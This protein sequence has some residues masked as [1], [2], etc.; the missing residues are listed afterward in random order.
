MGNVPANE[1]FH[2]EYGI[3]VVTAKQD[4]HKRPPKN[5]H[6]KWDQLEE[7][8]N[9]IS[10]PALKAAGTINLQCGAPDFAKLVC[11]SNTWGFMAD[12]C[13]NNGASKPT[14]RT[15]GTSWD[16]QYFHRPQVISRDISWGEIITTNYEVLANFAIPVKRSWISGGFWRCFFPRCSSG[17]WRLPK[18]CHLCLVHSDL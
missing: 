3:W 15:G 16:F 2:G 18:Q 8:E 7:C 1:Q 6:P 10:L 4:T 5:I 12:L 14:H 13:I 9:I 11:N 17:A